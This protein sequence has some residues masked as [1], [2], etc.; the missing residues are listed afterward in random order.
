MEQ[1]ILSS[2]WIIFLYA[3]FW[4][5][6][7]LIT[8]RNDFVDVARGLWYIVLCIYYFFVWD[9]SQ[10]EILIYG[11]ITL[12]WLR[13]A[14]TIFLKNIKKDEDF[15]YAQW[16]KDRWKYFYIR[17]YLQIYI[18]QGVL[19][20]IIAF[21]ALLVTAA[22][23]VPLHIRD[24][25]GVVLWLVWFFFEAVWDWQLAQFKKDP[26]NKWKIL[27][28]WLWKYTRHPNYFGEV[29]MWWAIFILWSSVTHGIY[30]IVSA[31]TITFLILYV[32]WIPM[33]EKKYEWNPDYE[34]YKKKTNKFFPWFPKK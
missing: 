3:T 33:L 22:E 20:W 4:F 1:L 7:S 30:G 17:S 29:V 28:T 10:R 31:L 27:D 12:W 11:L 32:S 9:G 14:I 15:R 18:L 13:L 19:M 26:D 24:V 2:L 6:V 5:V 23:P 21:P 16:R 8:K 25:F 34:A